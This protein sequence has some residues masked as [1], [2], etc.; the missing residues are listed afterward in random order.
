MKNKKPFFRPNIAI[1]S[2]KSCFL[3]YL[4]LWL[5]FK[6]ILTRS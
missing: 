2:I 5:S 4:I 1:L 6:D 3:I